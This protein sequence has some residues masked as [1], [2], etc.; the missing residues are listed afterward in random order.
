MKSATKSPFIE[1][2]SKLGLDAS[3]LDASLRDSRSWL[4][5]G[6][7]RQTC[8]QFGVDVSIDGATAV[9]SAPRDR[10]QL[11]AERLHFCRI[12]FLIL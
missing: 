4:Q 11:V 8:K 3:L 6:T 7:L 10:L 9:L 12:P 5:L 1:R 2:P